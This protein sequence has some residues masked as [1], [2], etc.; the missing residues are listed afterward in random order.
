MP[1]PPTEEELALTHA[2]RLMLQRIEQ[3]EQGLHEPL[4]RGDYRALTF[5]GMG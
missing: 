3:G 4:H 5:A 2:V 1:N